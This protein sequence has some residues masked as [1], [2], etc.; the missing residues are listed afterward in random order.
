[1][2]QTIVMKIHRWKIM[3][4]HNSVQKF[5]QLVVIIHLC[6]FITLG[7]PYKY[8]SCQSGLTHQQI[9]EHRKENSFM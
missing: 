6:I 4:N 7:C 1:M 2:G 8:T 9:Q 5:L 3:I